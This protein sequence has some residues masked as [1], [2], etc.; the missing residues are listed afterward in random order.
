M[1]V[2]LD[3]KIDAQSN[4]VYDLTRRPKPME[5]PSDDDR[6][7]LTALAKVHERELE[8][9]RNHLAWVYTTCSVYMGPPCGTSE[10]NMLPFGPVSNDYSMWYIRNHVIK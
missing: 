10:Y 5:F 6:T 8:H 7:Q 2:L 4:R 3:L 9:L 1:G